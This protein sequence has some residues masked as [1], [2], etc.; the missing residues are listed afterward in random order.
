MKAAELMGLGVNVQ[1]TKYRKVT[2]KHGLI[3][4]C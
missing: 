2:I 3:I 1:K 4:K